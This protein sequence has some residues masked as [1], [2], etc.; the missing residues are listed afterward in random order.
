MRF[1]IKFIVLL[2]LII[3]ISFAIII[4]GNHYFR[5]LKN[6]FSKEIIVFS[7]HLSVSSGV[8]PHHLL[9][10]EIIQKFF[11]ILSLKGK[12]ENIVL[13]GSDHFNSKSLCKKTSFITLNY[14]SKNFKNLK[15]DEFL[16]KSLIEK[17]DFCFNNSSVERDYGIINLLPYIKNYF[18]DTKI[19]PILI[20]S[21]ITEKEITSLIKT[22][23]SQS[24]S[25][26]IVIASVDF[27]H[28]LPKIAAQFY[29]K[30]SIR[31]LLNFE[32]EE[33]ENI[34]VDCWQCLYGARLFAKLQK[35]E[36][37][38]IITYKNSTDFFKNSNIDKTTSYFSVIFEK[39]DKKNYKNLESRKVK[40]LLFVGDIMLD[41][42]IESLMEKNSIYYPF[43]KIHQF[44]KGVDF[45]V[46]NLEGPIVKNPPNFGVHSLKFAFS[47]EVTK[48]LSFSNFNL[49]SLANNHTFDMG[50]TGFKETKEFLKQ[51]HINFVGHPIRCDKDFLFKK[52]NIIILAFNKTFPF[53]CS[54]EKITEI[55]KKIRKSNPKKFLIVIFHWGEEYQPKSSVFQQKLAHKVIEA[56]ADLIIGSHPHVVQEIEKHQ[57]KLI[58]YSLG[59]F[60]FDQYFSK[61]TQESLS[62]GLEIYPEKVIYW[63]F[64]I[65]SKLG[66]P[67]LMESENAYS[68][69]EKLAIRS[70][71]KL[72][73]EIKQGVIEISINK[74]QTNKER[75]KEMKTNKKKII[76]ISNQKF[77]KVDFGPFSQLKG[78]LV[79]HLFDIN[80]VPSPKAVTFSVDGKE[81]W[82]THL[83]NKRKGVSVFDSKTGEEIAT[84]NLNNN[85]GVEIEFSKDGKKAYVSQMETG[86]IFEIDTQSKKI[87]RVFDTKS[88]WTKVV[89]L[90]F[91]QKTL[92][93]SNWCGDNVSKINLLDGKLIKNI[94]T[95]DTPRG[96]YITED[97]KNLY[98]AGF[99][100]GEIEKIDL[101]TGERKVIFK[102]DGAMR[103]IVG[104]EEKGVL[105]VSDMAKNTIWKVYLKTDKVEKFVQTDNNPNTIVLSP[106]KK[107]LFV[108]CRGKNFSSTNYYIPGPEWGSILLFDTE[109]GKM[110]DAIVG[111]N[112]P[113][114]L[115][116][117]PDGK[118]LT[119]SDF[120]DEKIEVFEIPSYKILK[121]GNGGASKI[122]KKKLKK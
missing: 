62:L 29:D 64:P 119:F 5:D 67:F 15:V 99:A 66:Q 97:G 10:K 73:K 120:L 92:F 34:E 43:E 89:K 51:S 84:I 115:D 93:A 83:L 76:K 58:F 60:V 2:F 74:N 31:V 122:Y 8:V 39:G 102:S 56:G 47:P 16:L 111:G 12:P 6:L 85:G 37:P 23:D 117:S 17:N 7:A 33:F 75:M 82:A 110:L 109:T 59:N 46:G 32:K 72:I 116:I 53:N 87:L 3:L 52:E 40:T 9:A 36:K 54:D 50:E 71:P 28:Y 45:V 100:N 26:T 55:V 61:E 35:K 14:Q 81:I 25:K 11:K 18:P 86:K 21:D 65:Q 80:Y 114:G 94:P 107:I 91:N 113:T 27:S 4:G 121:N 88:S 38:E 118:F 41:R 68:F 30:K 96:I 48:V 103:H 79:R 106:D 101:D 95:V 1:E 104:N 42:G 24:S 57:G 77:K 98:V 112:Q 78:Q 69:F 70:D 44:L 20:P 49:V 105:Y 108:S 63:L 19:L 90:S 13:L 22:I